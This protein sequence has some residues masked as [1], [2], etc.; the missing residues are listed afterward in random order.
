MSEIA[1]FLRLTANSEGEYVG[2]CI[3]LY[4][5]FLLV[6]CIIIIY[7]CI[8][9][10]ISKE[11][12]KKDKRE[13]LSIILV[14]CIMWGGI[15]TYLHSYSIKGIENVNYINELNCMI[16]DE[17]YGLKI[18]VNNFVALSD[19]DNRCEYSDTS[20]FDITVD[21][22]NK[23]ITLKAKSAPYTGNAW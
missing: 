12:S 18:M 16:E 13:A 9:W 6:S 2:W 23:L 22:E 21:N 20:N 1:D 5:L 10:L 19:K 14:L 4:V 8:K 3:S 7:Q 17:G 15:F 11:K